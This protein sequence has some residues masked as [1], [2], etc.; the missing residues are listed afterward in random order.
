MRDIS[1]GL[2]D[3]REEPEIISSFLDYLKYAIGK[4]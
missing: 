3:P 1:E 2:T 4:M